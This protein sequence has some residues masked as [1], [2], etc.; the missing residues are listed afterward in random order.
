L[1]I[2][3]KVCSWF[4]RPEH[5][6][7][8]VKIRDID[9]YTGMRQGQAALSDERIPEDQRRHSI[10]EMHAEQKKGPG[11]KVLSVVRAIF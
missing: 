10:T 4:I 2:F 3:W 8:Y 6:P 11:A 5:R 1:Y 9:I 7:F